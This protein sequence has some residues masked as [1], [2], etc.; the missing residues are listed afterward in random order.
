M[1]PVYYQ[2]LKHMVMDKMHA[3]ARG[4]RVML[5]RQPTEGRSRDGGLRL[6]VE[7]EGRGREPEGGGLKSLVALSSCRDHGAVWLSGWLAAWL[8]CPVGM[9]CTA[10]VEDL[11]LA[12]S[13]LH[14]WRTLC[15]Y[16]VHCMC[17]GPCVG[18]EC[19]ACVE[20][21]V[22]V[23]S[24]LHVLG[25]RGGWVHVWKAGPLTLAPPPS[26]LPPPS[27]MPPP[28]PRPP[29]HTCPPPMPQVRWSATA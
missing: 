1:G 26:H 7:G 8:G 22:L 25:M 20:D 4:P 6:G 13:A 11:V 3:R 28:T 9:E 12:W 27:H 23:W 14:V 24:A 2:K 15:W 29:L 19:T 18:I 17:G 21:L 16:G 5:T 10:C